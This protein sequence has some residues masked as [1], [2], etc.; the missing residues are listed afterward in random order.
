[1]YTHITV[2]KCIPYNF[3]MPAV[4]SIYSRPTSCKEVVHYCLISIHV[5]ATHTYAA[6]FKPVIP[7]CTF[8]AGSVKINSLS[9]R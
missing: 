6:V 3:I 2:L 8:Y 1:M 5:T 4:I 9:N 7:Y